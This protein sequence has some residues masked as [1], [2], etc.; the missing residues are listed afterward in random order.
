MLCA[1]AVLAGCASNLVGTW[2]VNWPDGRKDTASLQD[3][4]K[5][6]W[7]L[8][9]NTAELNGVYVFKDSRLTCVA[10]EM[11]TMAGFVWNQ[12]SKNAFT[13]VQ[14]AQPTRLH[15]HWLGTRLI[16]DRSR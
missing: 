11:P 2:D 15:D 5:G 16:R 6:Q 10:P 7:Y 1:G 3:F 13:L 4:G 14:Q 9:S 12:N 8:R